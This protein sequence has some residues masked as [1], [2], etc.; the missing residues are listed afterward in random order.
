MA[1]PAL[2]LQIRQLEQE[3]GVELLTRHSR[4]VMP[5]E[6]GSLLLER[7]RVILSM[8]EEAKR[9]VRALGGARS[10]TLTLGLTP[11]IMLL[12]GPDVL[13]SA[14]EEMP[15]VYLS[16]VEELSFLLLEAIERGEVQ[17]ALAYDVPERPG[18]ERQA[19]LEEELLL[20]S[21]PGSEPVGDTIPLAD[22]LKLDLVQAGERD[23]V[24][25]IIRTAAERLSLPVR[26]AYEV[27]SV[28]AMRAMACRGAAASIMPY[29]IAVEELKSGRLIGRRIVEPILQ[30]TLYLVRP[31]G[32]PPFRCGAEIDRFLGTIA[33]RLVHSLGPLAKALA[34]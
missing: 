8:V 4:G 18:L 12:L 31:A 10:E 1:Q 30:R 9:D 21:K 14:R 29:G 16:I 7:A 34:G 27:Q 17:V 24:R 32:Q 19:V 28:T 15:N 33:Q 20:V 6:A 22:A 23:M 26:V 5:T 2:G 11:S 25:R 3:L 13:I